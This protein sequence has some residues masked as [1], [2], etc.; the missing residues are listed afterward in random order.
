MVSL[1]DI[2]READKHLG[3]LPPGTPLDEATAALIAFAVRIS[4][5]SLD[6]AGADMFARRAL[7][8]GITADQLHEAVILMSGVGVHS[9]F[10]GTRLVARL[11]DE[12][13]A[14]DAP[15]SEDHQQLWDSTIGR[16][17][18]WDGLEREVPG[19]LKTLMRTSKSCFD[20][21]FRYCAVP[22]KSGHL[23]V[24]TKELM[25]MAADA[26]P[27]H[28][29]MP[30][31]RLHLLNAIRLGAGRAAITQTLDIAAASPEH[32]GVG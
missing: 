20:A 28:R 19:F 4:V 26:T 11:T 5:T 2:R 25:S 14:S 29:Y 9:L 27:T 16:D 23:P 18:Y 6:V 7:A 3:A 30:G 21:F 15:L 32:P 22:W 10:E 13:T 12:A 24:L 8:A 31:M 1:Q 17:K